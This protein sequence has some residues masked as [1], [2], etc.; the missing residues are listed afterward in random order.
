MIKIDHNKKDSGMSI[1][2]KEFFKNLKLMSFDLNGFLI[3][4][5][6]CTQQSDVIRLQS[7]FSAKERGKI[8]M[9]LS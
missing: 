7:I 2:K 3:F 6:F 5:E 4:H 8:D 1:L 9:S